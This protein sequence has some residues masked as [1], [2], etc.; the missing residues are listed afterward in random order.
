M[1]SPQNERRTAQAASSYVKIAVILICA[2]A[3]ISAIALAVFNRVYLAENGL[4]LNGAPAALPISLTVIAIA[5]CVF[6]TMNVRRAHRLDCLP[7]TGNVAL[8][9]LSFLITAEFFAIFIIY[10]LLGAA[11]LQYG[12]GG[13]IE[14]NPALAEK[15]K[16]AIL[17][18]KILMP[19]SLFAPIYFIVAAFKKKISALFG[20]VTLA[21]IILYIL[22]LYFD[23]TDWVMSPRKLTMICAMCIAALFILY[24]IRFAFSRGSSRKYFFFAALASI[25]CIGCGFAG[26]FSVLSGVY[27]LNYELP[28]YGA[29]L[30]IGIYAL[31]RV[32][33]FIPARDDEDEDAEKV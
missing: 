3:V 17:C 23:V 19:L 33:S 10:F 7:D 20:S 11:D 8:T 22:R 29:C 27:P 5:A 31:I 30:L 14:S 4:Y 12:F 13:S 15:M 28:Y 26:V 9:M 1:N 16:A 21:W 6:G 25:F 24:E 32:I 2:V 18:Y